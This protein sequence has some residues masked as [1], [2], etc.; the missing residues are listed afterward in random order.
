MLQYAELSNRAMR[1]LAVLRITLAGNRRYN[2]G[3]GI[4]VPRIILQN[5][6]R[7]VTS[8]FRSDNRVQIRIIHLSPCNIVSYLPPPCRSRGLCKDRQHMLS[9]LLFFKPALLSSTPRLTG[10]H[11]AADGCRLHGNRTPPRIS[12]S[13]PHLLRRI[14][15]ETASTLDFMA[16]QEYRPHRRSWPHT[17]P[18]CADSRCSS[19]TAIRSKAQ[20]GNQYKV[21]S[22]CFIRQVMAQLLR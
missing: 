10:N 1:R 2:D 16:G 9:V 6:N 13:C 7:P 21:R 12:P 4:P 18:P 11:Q 15:A 5:Q 19:L 17:E 3:V 20:T 22:G 14:T 8:L